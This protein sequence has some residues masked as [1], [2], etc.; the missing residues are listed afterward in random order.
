VTARIGWAPDVGGGDGVVWEL[1]A[2]SA[3][4]LVVFVPPALRQY[5]ATRPDVGTAQREAPSSSRASAPRTAAC[6]RRCTPSL[7]STPLT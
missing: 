7:A 1:L 2:W 6:V 4:L 5:P 3:G